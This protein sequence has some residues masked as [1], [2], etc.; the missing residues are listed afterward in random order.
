MSETKM[1]AQILKEETMGFFNAVRDKVVRAWNSLHLFV[2]IG[3]VVVAGLI[4]FQAV[5]NFFAG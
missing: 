3:I 5:A 4:A 2:Q 1:L